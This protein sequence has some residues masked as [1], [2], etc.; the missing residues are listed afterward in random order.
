MSTI[1]KYMISLGVCTIMVLAG[2]TVSASNAYADDPGTI[3]LA[4]SPTTSVA[5][6]TV[7]RAHRH[8]YIKACE[9]SRSNGGRKIRLAYGSF[10][11]PNPDGVTTVRAG[12]CR[13][14]RVNRKNIDWVAYNARTGAIIAAGRV[15][16]IHL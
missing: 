6:P 12:H 5:A 2:L 4:P 9:P 7:K 8:G 1:K 13:L 10:Q 16:H 11:Q 3:I 14:I 15:R